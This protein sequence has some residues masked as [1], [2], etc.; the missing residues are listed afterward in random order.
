MKNFPSF[1]AVIGAWLCALGFVYIG[2]VVFILG[3]LWAIFIDDDIDFYTLAF[4]A[5][6]VYG[7]VRFSNAA[8]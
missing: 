7:F 4:L 3:S 5:A 2:L 8:I 1:L 6:N